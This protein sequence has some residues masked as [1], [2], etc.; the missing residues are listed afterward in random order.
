[1]YRRKFVIPL[2]FIVVIAVAL[3]LTSTKKNDSATNVKAQT[4][5]LH[6]SGDAD[7]NDA[8]NM[9]DFEIFRKEFI[10]TLT[11]KTADFNNDGAVNTIDFELWRRGFFTPAATP[12]TLIPTAN[13]TIITP[14][15]TSIHTSPT[16]TK[17][18]TPTPLV[19]SPTAIRTPTPVLTTTPNPTPSGCTYPAQI[20]NLTNWKETLPIGSSKP[21][22][23]F[24][25]QLATYTIDPWFKVNATCTGVQFRAHTSSPVTTSNSSYPRSELREMTSN[26]TALAAWSS[27][28][29]THTM[30]IDEAITAVPTGKKHIVAGQIHD[31]SNDVIVIRLEYPK[32]YI[33]IN[34]T[35]GPILDPAYTLGKRFTVKFVVSGG[36]INVYYNGSPTAA[37]TLS[38]SIVSSYFKAG[39][40]T[41]SNC[42]TE[43]QR[44]AQCSESNYGEVSIYGLTVRHE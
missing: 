35:D 9:T 33:D 40:Y 23:I 42:T 44:G 4:C 11:T 34:G 1:M 13:P 43:Q 36:K 2:F 27:T 3:V 18:P 19:P 22:E 7:C 29:G 30:F 12:T 39:A 17:T 5:A 20:L 31:A 41:Q 6:S 24:Q 28:S 32:L 37:F 38:K 16:S 15:P 25:P 26:G 10:G 14:S 21:T 8:V